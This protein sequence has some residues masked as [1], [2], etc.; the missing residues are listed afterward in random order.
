V[1]CWST[2]WGGI[3]SKPVS[4]KPQTAM[5]SI[6]NVK[7]MLAKPVGWWNILHSMLCDETWIIEYL[8]NSD[9]EYQESIYMAVE[10][11]PSVTLMSTAQMHLLL[12]SY[13]LD[14]LFLVLWCLRLSKYPRYSKCTEVLYDHN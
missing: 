2:L 10:G 7:S 1:A 9:C 5:L 6:M 11:F 12:K 13:W 3:S 4:L 14:G 8:S